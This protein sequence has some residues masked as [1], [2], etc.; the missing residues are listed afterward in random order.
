MVGRE[1]HAG[2]ASLALAATLVCGCAL[3]SVRV[4]QRVPVDRTY[5]S[6]Y[7]IVYEG[8]GDY[9]APRFARK[10]SGAMMQALGTHTPARWSRIL[11]GL[12]FDT[13]SVDRDIDSVGAQAV[14]TLR[15]LGTRSGHHGQIVERTYG[16]TLS[17]R[18]S[19]QPLWAAKVDI[20]GAYELGIEDVAGK[21]VDS[22]TRDHLLGP[23]VASN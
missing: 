10:L 5:A 16:V 18:P 7:V 6:V 3:T 11:T 1:R 22:L 23:A 21:I 9:Y 19:N 17:D 2:V 4:V 12:E 15:P 8:A 13:S 20:S 14:L